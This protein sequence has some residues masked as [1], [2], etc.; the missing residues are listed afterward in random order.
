MAPSLAVPPVPE[1]AR[2]PGVPASPRRR[3]PW[4]AGTRPTAPDRSGPGRAPGCQP[5]AM[6]WVGCRSLEAAT[7]EVP[8][9]DDALDLARP[10]ADATDAQFAVPALE[11]EILGH[12]RT[13][14]DLHRPVDHPAGRLGRHQLGHGRLG[15]EGLAAIGLG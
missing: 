12:A 9:H 1:P 2:P 13:A 10:F 11:R 15:A 3:P 7:D 6:R 5:A 4:P 8:R 14:V